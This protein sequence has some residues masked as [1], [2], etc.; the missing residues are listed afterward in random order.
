ML[1]NSGRPA[2]ERLGVTEAKRKYRIN[3][4]A[5][6]TG[7]SAATL[8][9]WERRYGV[10]VPSRTESSYRVY[11]EADIETIR[12]LRALCDEGMSPSE[13]AKVVLTETAAPPE[14]AANVGDPYGPSRQAILEAIERFDPVALDAAVQH[15]LAMGSATIIYDRVIREVMREVGTRWHAGAFTVGQE[16]LATQVMENAARR[17]LSLVQPSGAARQVVLACFADDDHTLPLYGVGLHLASAG[18]RVVLLGGK[19][20]ATAIRQSVGELSPACVGLSATMTPPPHV[21]RELIDAYGDACGTTPWVVGGRS[22]P[23]L[24]E[25]IEKAGGTVVG[26][27]DPRQLVRDIETLIARGRR[28]SRAQGKLSS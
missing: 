11:S 26:D 28:L 5:K 17:M 22:A 2:W 6:L 14:P 13:A 23:V 27:D 21:A 19:T 4:V 3:V 20:P 10:P 15:A 24:R 16:H 25:F 18:F 1:H 9:A 8:R 7:V 12:R